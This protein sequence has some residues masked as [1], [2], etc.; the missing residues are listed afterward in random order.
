MDTN[1][2]TSLLL[3]TAI[4]WSGNAACA[5]DLDD[6]TSISMLSKDAGQLEVKSWSLP[7]NKIL[8]SLKPA[9]AKMPKREYKGEISS[10]DGSDVIS[11]K[12]DQLLDVA[13][14][15]S[16]NAERLNQ[17]VA[18]YSKT[19]RKA[20]TST[21]DAVDYMI[22]FTGFATSSEAGDIILDEK[23]KVK[24]LASAEFARQKQ[25]DELHLQLV[26]SMLQIAMGLGATDQN[27]GQS[28]V[29]EGTQQL[30]DLIG[31]QETENALAAI[32]TWSASIKVPEA[33]FAQ[34][35]WSIKQQ[36][37]K[38]KTVLDSALDNDPI[39]KGVTKSLHK[40]NH[41]SKLMRTTGKV[42]ETTLGIA[43]FTP[44]LVG[45]AAQL[46]LMAFILAT[47]GPEEDKL[48]KEL[49]LDKRLQS[50]ATVLN[51]KAVMA[52]SNYQTGILTRNPVVM[53]LAESLVADM[54]GAESVNKVF[55][56][57]ILSP[58]QELNISAMSPEDATSFMH[59]ENPSALLLTN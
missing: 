17:A 57:S 22:P 51:Q 21:L 25:I 10:D 49:Y 3:C 23:L 11:Q 13:W 5:N 4:L 34:D 56:R 59:M 33:V 2:L 31:E 28:M 46:G 53:A 26:S 39:V 58:A 55:C 50:R 18:T 47:G 45:P 14:Q 12:L 30:Q 1:K 8:E 38:L 7:I 42:V 54:S 9:S 29:A 16:P 37:Y 43:A 6:T 35:L 24:S 41:R 19:S 52:L 48:M 40:Y 20:L 27:R 36:E 44:T 15:R 32:K